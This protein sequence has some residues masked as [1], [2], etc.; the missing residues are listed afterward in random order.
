MLS[1]Q[2]FATRIT[3]SWLCVFVLAG[4]VGCD[5]GKP[6]TDGKT[7]PKNASTK[8]ASIKDASTKDAPKKDDSAKD[9]STKDVS[10]KDDSTKA[11]VKTENEPISL[12]DGKTMGKWKVTNF[13]GE[14]PVEIKD[15]AMHISMGS[16]LSG[17]NWQGEPPLKMNYEISLEAQRVEGD[18]FFLGLTVPVKKNSIS[19]ILGG[20]GGTLVGLSSI[21]GMDASENEYTQYI[22]FKKEQWYKVKMVVKEKQILVFIDGKQ[23]IDA[24]I[25][26]R[27]IETRI[28]V[29]VSKPLGIATFSTAGAYRNIQMKKLE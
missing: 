21:D 1:I 22:N 2:S 3:L 26:G 8:D 27:K 25:D 14:G 18:D 12:F 9:S 13:G 6:Q 5:G 19:L 17:V 15:G 7:T 4:F 16:P 28:E 23:V 10:T 11:P 24:N 29:D 20:W